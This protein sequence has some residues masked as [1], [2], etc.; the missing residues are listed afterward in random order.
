MP[1]GRAA[2]AEIAERGSAKAG[3]TGVLPPLEAVA[4]AILDLLY[5]VNT[6]RKLVW[7]NRRLEAVT[8]LT[9]EELRARPAVE[10]VVEDD[11]ESL[12]Q[13]IQ[14][15]FSHGEA[16][17]EWRLITPSGPLLY[18]FNEVALKDGGGKVIGLA[19][20][21]R[22]V[23]DRR[24]A[25]EAA[26]RWT[27]LYQGFLTTMSDLGQAVAIVQD[28]RFV[29]A[30]DA[31]SQITGYSRDELLALPSFLALLAPEARTAAEER[32]NERRNGVDTPNHMEVSGL[33]KDG[34]RVYAEFS[35]KPIS[36]GGG[37]QFFA[38]IRDI[39][40]RKRAEHAARREASFVKLLQSI[41]TVA[42]GAET[43]AEALQFA[44]DRVRGHT[45]WAL[46]HVYLRDEANGEFVSSGIWSADTSALF[47]DFRELTEAAP[48]APGTG[49]AG[50]V[51]DTAEAV[52]ITDITVQP[53]F[54]GAKQAGIREG[55]AFPVLVGEEIAAV[56]E[57]FSTE[58]E[59]PDEKLLEVMMHVG[60]QL[61][62]VI[63]R[64]RAQEELQR[65][66]DRFRRLVESSPDAIAVY[67]GDGVIAL[68]NEAAAELVGAKSP[69]DLVGKTVWDFV[70]PDDRDTIRERGR[71][72]ADGEGT[73]PPAELRFVRLDGE[74]VY[75]ESAAR[76]ITYD[77]RPAVQVS[78]RDVTERRRQ[79]RDL[80]RARQDLEQFAYV[81]SHDLQEPLRMVS[82]YLQ[83]LERRYK[84][85]LD[86]DADDF[87][88]FAV[89][90]AQRMQGLIN[91]L[92]AYSRVGSRGKPFEPTDL[93]TAVDE[94]VAAFQESVDE[95]RAIV[96]RDSL[97]TVVADASQVRQLYLN[98]IGNAMKFCNGRRP[99]IH[100][101]LKEKDGERVFFVRDNGI[102]IDQQYAERIFV[103][104]Q[105]LHSRDEYPGTGMGLA[106]CKRIVERR[107]GRIWVESK[108]GKG[109]TFFFTM[110]QKGESRV[111]PDR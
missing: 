99:R 74:S 103:I 50:R 88:H 23:S 3:T 44:V 51:A 20:V 54:A 78:A 2:R 49:L 33:H 68:A 76:L 46:G 27:E 12:E 17:G 8:G 6:E 21:G 67:T 5:V 26:R 36:L 37:K 13:A 93:N 69:Q 15:V 92:L 18:H 84:G 19:G 98:L 64:K 82:S 9:P 22:D 105:R 90:G 87:I 94:A 11:R 58:A 79:D 83:L 73:L 77:G 70:H 14:R 28:G 30:N 81:A 35:F 85:R 38:I 7:W 96:I 40:D 95:A 52:W 4:D 107:G 86:A 97:P 39:S 91:D 25:E 89:D 31:L 109:S 24:Q 48:F 108:P 57:F 100:V 60:T 34:Q 42:N 55:C 32:M 71:R 10:F 62:R 53:D 101:G 110:P 72:L 66:E 29:Y 56:L 61:G 111:G 59:E 45:G 41:S 80:E 65:S 63:E 75:V 104:F 102:G 47:E 106:I 16:Q 43:V 1:S